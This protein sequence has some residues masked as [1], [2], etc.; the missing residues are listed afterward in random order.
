MRRGDRVGRGSSVSAETPRGHARDGRGYGRDA[1]SRRDR[2]RRRRRPRSA[3]ADDR[4]LPLERHEAFEDRRAA[5]RCAPSASPRS[6]PA[7]IIDL[8]LA[9]VAEAAGLQHRG[10]ADASRRPSA[11][12]ASLV[13]GRERAP[14]RCRDRQ[15]RSFPSAGPASSRALARP[16]SSGRVRRQDR[17]RR[18]PGR[19][20]IRR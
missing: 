5:A 15:R 9:V 7:R 12:S 8:A 14:W 6:V 20:R 17:G 19:S 11:S 4:D 10:P 16:G 3:A 1:R 2:R 13:D 18:A